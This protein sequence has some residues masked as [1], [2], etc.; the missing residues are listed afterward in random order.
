MLTV[1]NQN[2]LIVMAL[3]ALHA[4]QSVHRIFKY[5]ILWSDHLKCELALTTACNARLKRH[6]EADSIVAGQNMGQSWACNL[7]RFRN[8]VNTMIPMACI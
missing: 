3:S 8:C 4:D 6:A 5:G 1:T 7:G 2:E